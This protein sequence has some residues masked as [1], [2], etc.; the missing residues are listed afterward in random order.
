MAEIN[1]EL[2]LKWAETAASA[3]FGLVSDQSPA[4]PPAD[5]N[6]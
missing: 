2:T 5:A 6:A 4:K 1:R 3:P